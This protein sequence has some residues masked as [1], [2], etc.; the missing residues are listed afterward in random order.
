VAHYEFQIEAKSAEELRETL[1]AIVAV[2]DFVPAAG[3][4][5]FARYPANDGAQIAIPIPIPIPPAAS[6]PEQPAETLA[7]VPKRRG[8]PPRNTN[9]SGADVAPTVVENPDGG[10]AAVTQ[11]MA[12]DPPAAVQEEEPEG[13]P[14][15]QLEDLDVLASLPPVPEDVPGMSAG[16]MRE[17]AIALMQQ[18]FGYAQGPD[19]VRAVHRRLKVR[20]IADVPDAQC[21]ELLDD[22]TAVLAQLK[23]SGSPMI[24]TA[25]GKSA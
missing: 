21:R 16:D 13:P 8:R 7:P 20:K 5:S 6:A 10:L 23:A 11:P 12:V 25:V 1:M 17:R 24:L 9:G 19:L 4:L 18:A 2:L 22:A 14:A 3:R 15:K